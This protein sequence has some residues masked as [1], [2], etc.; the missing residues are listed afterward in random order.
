MRDSTF[1]VELYQD[2]YWDLA[3]DSVEMCDAARFAA[4]LKR[5]HHKV[6]VVPDFG[7]SEPRDRFTVAEY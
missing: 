6:R 2:P 3:S 1:H 5:K 4:V 7:Y